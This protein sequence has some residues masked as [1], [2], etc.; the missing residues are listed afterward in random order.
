M[1]SS[2]ASPSSIPPLPPR[3]RP[4]ASWDERAAFWRA[5]LDAYAAS[6]LNVTDFCRL[7][8]L[9]KFSFYSWRKTLHDRSAVGAAPAFIEVTPAPSTSSSV[10]AAANASGADWLA[11]LAR[12]SA[13]LHAHLC[14]GPR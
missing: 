14:E 5:C 8:H 7:A 4:K 1:P 2:P 11:E 13:A 12:L 9:G 10:P 3:P 6:G